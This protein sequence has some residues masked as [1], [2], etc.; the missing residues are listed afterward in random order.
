MKTQELNSPFKKCFKALK[1]CNFDTHYIVSTE[2]NIKTFRLT[3][4]CVL[5]FEKILKVR[6]HVCVTTIYGESLKKENN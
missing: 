4:L 6:I 3:S 1:C 5:I 2:G